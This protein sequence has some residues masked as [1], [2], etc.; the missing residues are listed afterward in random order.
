MQSLK[1]A[2]PELFA[3]IAEE[4]K[5]QVDCIELIASEVGSVDFHATLAN[6][7]VLLLFLNDR[8]EGLR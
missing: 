1:D 7:L 4:K 2:D 6:I 5:R 8:M 3:L